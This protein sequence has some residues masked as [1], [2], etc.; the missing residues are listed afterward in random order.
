[1]PGAAIPI[2]APV[3]PARDMSDALESVF[4][5]CSGALYRFF[6]VR[7]GNDQ[8]LADDLMQQLW[9]HARQLGPTPPEQIEFRLR[10]IALNLIRTHWRKQQ[11]R[12]HHVPLARTDLA[13][14]LAQ[15]LATEELPAATLERQEVQDQLLLALTALPADQQQLLVAHY[16]D[17]QAQTTLARCAGTSPRA[18]EGR[19][20]RARQALREKLRHLEPF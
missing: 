13:A 8:T 12:P 2:P 14:E 4:D 17:G 19:L 10:A 6:V 5:H 1:M 15:Q 18:I 7:T 20:Y 16:F 11:R 3:T 9:L